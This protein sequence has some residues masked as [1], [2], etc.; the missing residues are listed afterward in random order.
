MSTVHDDLLNDFGSSGDEADEAEDNGLILNKDTDRTNADGADEDGV[1]DPDSMDVDATGPEV[2]DDDDATAKTQQIEKMQLGAVKDVR[3]VATL[4]QT[5]EP[6]LEVSQT[7]LLLP[8]T[9]RL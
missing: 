1:D 3:S 8:L 4:M 7:L 9:L 5:L 6:I 2:G